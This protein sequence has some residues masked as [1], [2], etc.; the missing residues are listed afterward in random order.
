MSPVDPEIVPVDLESGY[1]GLVAQLFAVD[2]AAV[3]LRLEGFSEQRVEGLIEIEKHQ[4]IR[5]EKCS[6]ILHLP[7]HICF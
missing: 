2:L 5:L 6:H 7:H 1:R 3:Q 4:D